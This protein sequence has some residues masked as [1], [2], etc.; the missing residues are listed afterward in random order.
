MGSRSF[1]REDLILALQTAA[2]TIT[3]DESRG[4]ELKPS[5]LGTQPCAIRFDSGRI[6][7]SGFERRLDGSVRAAGVR[8]AHDVH[9][10][11]Q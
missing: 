8:I 9:L 3:D 5:D 11:G 10:L 1:Y 2:S 6:R 7:L 4:D